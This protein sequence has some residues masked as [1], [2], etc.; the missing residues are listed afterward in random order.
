[1]SIAEL[2][3]WFGEVKVCAITTTNFTTQMYTIPG[4]SGGMVVNDAGELVGVVSAGG[5]GFSYL[6]RLLDIQSFLAS[7]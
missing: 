3:S 7:Y 4:S 1:M 5:G 2:M 6:V